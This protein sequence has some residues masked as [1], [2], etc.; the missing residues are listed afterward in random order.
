LFSID[1]KD[2]RYKL[3]GELWLFKIKI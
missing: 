1:S 3:G 2:I